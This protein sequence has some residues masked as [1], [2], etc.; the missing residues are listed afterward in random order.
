MKPIIITGTL[1]L[2]TVIL[3]AQDPYLDFIGAGHDQGISVLTSSDHS[4]ADGSFVA[5]GLSTVSGK[6]LDGPSMEAAR[7]LAQASFGPSVGEIERVREMGIETWIDEQLNIDPSFL[8]PELINVY[9][10]ALEVFT[11][12]GGIAVNYDERPSWEHF[13][14]TWWQVNLTGPDLLRQKVAYALSQVLVISVESGLFDK[15]EA[16]ADYYDVLIK[17][18]FGNYRDLL[19]EVTLHPAM[20]VY[21]SHL[22]NPRELPEQNI[23]PDENYAR[24]V[25]QLFSIGLFELNQDGTRKTDENG[26]F[27]PTYDNNDIKQL[28]RVFTG[29][30]AG[31]T[32]SRDDG[33]LPQFNLGMD[34]ID[35]TVPMRMYE[36]WHEPGSK[37]LIGGLILP[38]GQDGMT[39]IGQAIDHLF[40][41]PNTGPFLA[42][43]LIQRLVKSNPSP[44]YIARIAGVFNDNGLGVRG[45]LASVVKA[46]LLDEEAR[47]CEWLN[48]PE[49]GRLRE[50]ISRYTHFVQAIGMDNDLGLFWNIGE[51][52][53][54]SVSQHPLHSPTVF[55]F[56]LPDFQPNGPIA[57][58]D[59]NGPEFQIHNT[60]TS[61][62][63]ANLVNDWAVEGELL[64]TYEE[65][66]FLTRTEF[67]HL[68]PFARYP[69]PLI[70]R[71][72][73]LLTHGQ[74]SD[75]TRE[76]ILEAISPFSEN[77]VGDLYRLKLALY[78][79]M[80][81]PDYTV[82][83]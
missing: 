20:G 50:P 19:L 74:L 53:M 21:L 30:G 29:L 12:N 45:D 16:L 26:D 76:I 28:A 81:S 31:G 18:A 5:A 60:K 65:D 55:N 75:R 58:R 66:G 47:S 38:E 43:R 22:N 25:M 61:I 56:Y 6:G 83:R 37:E 32:I 40:N 80:I 64:Y 59:L 78:L 8:L 9:H 1:L 71:L 44:G 2:F 77:A 51:P 48:D 3:S 63:Y 35:F 73:V 33:L 52:L 79:F 69:E 67:G 17:H 13:D 82:L 70:N 36:E 46:I 24:E 72:D 27:I 42:T 7:F 39:D 41:H 54:N 4:D 34:V 23:H 62:G 68:L 11:D 15:G 10:T 57:E 49:Q 14:Y